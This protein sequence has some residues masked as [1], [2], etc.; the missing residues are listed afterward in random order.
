VHVHVLYIFRFM[1]IF[2]SMFMSCSSLC[3]CVCSCSC[4]S[5]C[6]C[7]CSCA[8]SCSCLLYRQDADVE[9]ISRQP[10]TFSLVQYLSDVELG[11]GGKLTTK[12]T[13]GGCS[14]NTWVL[15]WVSNI[16]RSEVWDLGERIFLSAPYHSCYP[17]RFLVIINHLHSF[18]YKCTYCGNP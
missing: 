5:S 14:H 8:C 18:V 4:S 16:S 7:E 1:F 6:P 13:P 3:S 12:G 17:S 9:R 2:T 10:E 11:N 15:K